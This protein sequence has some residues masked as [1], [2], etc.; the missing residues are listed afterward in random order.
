MS[1]TLLEHLDMQDDWRDLPTFLIGDFNAYSQE[2]AIAVLNDAGYATI[3]QERPSYQYDN[4][5]GSLDHVLA[6]DAAMDLVKDSLVW[7]INSDEPLIDEPGSPFRSSDHN[8]VKVGFD[9]T[10]SQSLS[11]LRAGWI[12]GAVLLMAL[13]AALVLRPKQIENSF[14]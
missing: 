11:Y 13:L 12:V 7:A 4:K 6:N 1:R 8:P 5:V 14:Q 9:A 10:S 3:P 2:D